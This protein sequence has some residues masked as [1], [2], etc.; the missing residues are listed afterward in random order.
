MIL[1]RKIKLLVTASVSSILSLSVNAANVDYKKAMEA[2]LMLPHLELA[3]VNS[4]QEMVQFSQM[5]TSNDLAKLKTTLPL[6]KSQQYYMRVTGAEL[7]KGLSIDTS[8]AGALVRISPTKGSNSSSIKV[9]ELK[10]T[11]PTGNKMSAVD[12]MEFKANS[13]DL[14][15][16]PF[17]EG[18]SVFKFDSQLGAGKFKINTTRQ[19]MDKEEFIVNVLE[20]KSPF[21]LSLRTNAHQVFAGENF[22]AKLQLTNLSEKTNMLSSRTNKQQSVSPKLTAVKGKLVAPDGQEY[23]VKFSAS[24]NGEFNLDMPMT[25]PLSAAQGLWEVKVNT[26]GQN[27]ALV[28]KRDARLAFAYNPVTAV[29]ENVSMPRQ[30][31]KQHIQSQVTVNAQYAGRY[32]VKGILY[33]KQK[34]RLIPMMET[35]TAMW[36]EVGDN[37]VPL[38]F[39]KVREKFHSTSANTWVVKNIT[40]TDQSRMSV[41]PQD[42]LLSSPILERPRFVQEKVSQKKLTRNR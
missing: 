17:P 20:K 19:L 24:K 12:A 9:E 18:T 21:Q 2:Q 42:S 41:F 34:G 11:T 26:Q 14:Q 31:A 29:V 3:S 10:I 23:P 15:A 28:I 36:L 40:L 1:K 8:A 16:T 33:G 5:V 27:G 25:L 32:E 4:R 39:D 35:R 37:Q 13:K 30:F 38:L 22:S 7:N 6:V